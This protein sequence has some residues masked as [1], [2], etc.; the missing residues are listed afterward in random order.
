MCMAGNKDGRVYAWQVT[1]ICMAGNK[2]GRVY[3][4]V[5][6]KICRF[7]TKMG[8]FMQTCRQKYANP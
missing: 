3:A 6:T 8:E 2:D 5:Q 1:T 4:N 7:V